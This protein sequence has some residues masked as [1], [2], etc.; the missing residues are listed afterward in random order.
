MKSLNVKSLSKK[1]LIPNCCNVIVLIRF[2][3]LKVMHDA[4]CVQVNLVLILKVFNC[5][6]IFL[7][8]LVQSP[9]VMESGMGKCHTTGPVFSHPCYLPLI[10]L[11]TTL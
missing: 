6:T 7:V 10:W 2:L 9:G 8:V 11:R 3:F 4:V 5:N 1:H